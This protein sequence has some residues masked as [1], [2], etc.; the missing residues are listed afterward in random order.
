MARKR[1]AR[2][3]GCRQR[4]LRGGSRNW[5]V[6]PASGS[7]RHRTVG[8]PRG[9]VR[10]GHCLNGITR[11][12]LRPGREH[13]RWEMGWTLGALRLGRDQRR[14]RNR[15]GKV[16]RRIQCLGALPGL[17]MRGVWAE[18]RKHLLN[19]RLLTRLF[20][21]N[22]VQCFGEKP[23]GFSGRKQVGKAL[24]DPAHSLP[25]VFNFRLHLVWLGL[26]R[27]GF[28]GQLRFLSPT[29][30]GPLGAPAIPESRPERGTSRGNR[31][32]VQAG[33]IAE[34]LSA[35]KLRRRRRRSG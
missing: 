6:W 4:N 32:S 5:P 12:G 3:I 26:S 18:L 28:W 17:R 13:R 11:T 15:R 16:A 35:Q 8:C 24:A 31:R 25:N 9:S 14:S 10:T 23:S 33:R 21:A 27:S 22:P 7:E 2:R 30:F 19:Q 1:V 29:R 20:L 34:L